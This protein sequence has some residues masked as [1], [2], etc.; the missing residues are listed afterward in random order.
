MTQQQSNDL[1]QQQNKEDKKSKEQE[2][3]IKNAVYIAHI[4]QPNHPNT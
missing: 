1:Q 4:D 3:D 2:Q